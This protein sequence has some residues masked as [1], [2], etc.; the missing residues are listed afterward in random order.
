MF[1]NE[2]ANQGEIDISEL[3]WLRGSQ[4][5]LRM[6]NGKEGG[7]TCLIEPSAI[8]P[9]PFLFGMAMVDAMRHGAKAYARAVSISEEH[10]LGRIWEGF[11][12]ERGSPTDEPRE[13]NPEGKPN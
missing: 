2:K 10:A 4:E 1:G 13:V 5:F 7:L 9:D 11:D 12:A 6:W 8:G 3:D